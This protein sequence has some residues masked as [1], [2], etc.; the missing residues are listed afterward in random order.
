V[1]VRKVWAE[2]TAAVPMD[3]QPVALCESAAQPRN[4]GITYNAYG[5]ELYYSLAKG[6]CR[7]FSLDRY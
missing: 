1:N 4:Q 5:G 3:G 6:Q 2:Y 7:V